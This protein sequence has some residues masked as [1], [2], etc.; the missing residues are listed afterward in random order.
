MAEKQPWNCQ[1][2]QFEDQKPQR[3]KNRPSNCQG[4]QYKNVAVK[5]PRSAVWVPPKNVVQTAKF[6]SSKATF[7]NFQIWQV[8]QV[9]WK[10]QDLNQIWLELEKLSL[11]IYCYLF[12]CFLTLPDIFTPRCTSTARWIPPARRGRTSS[13]KPW[14]TAASSSTST[15]R[16]TISA[17]RTN[18]HPLCMTRHASTSSRPWGS[19]ISGFIGPCRY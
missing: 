8:T 7:S 6:D 4:W 12:V 1:G 11:A 13:E 14:Q 10:Y 18:Q 15:E 9:I 2:L 19:Q 16:N 17:S 3:S 5:L